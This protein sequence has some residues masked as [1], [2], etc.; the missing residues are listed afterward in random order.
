MRQGRAPSGTT[1]GGLLPGLAQ[2]VLI[3]MMLAAPMARTPALAATAAWRGVSGPLLLAELPTDPA[4]QRTDALLPDV[5]AAHRAV[6]SRPARKASAASQPAPAPQVR[7]AHSR[8]V[9]GPPPG[10]ARAP[11][12]A[13]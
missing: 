6:T 13:G 2:L 7:Q 4:A 10:A 12:G 11:P 8:A 3:A 5:T 9:D 1:F